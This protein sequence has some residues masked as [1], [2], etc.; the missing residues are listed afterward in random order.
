MHKRKI[1][2]V[3]G[4]RADYGLLYWSL[5]KIQTDPSLE[6]CLIATGQHLSIKHGLTHK[7]IENDGFHINHKVEMLLDADTSQSLIKGT[8]LGF[9]G[10]GL[11]LS[12]EN[13]DLLLVLGDR[14]E[15]FA[16]C[17]AATLLKLPIAHI[18][19]GEST[20][21]LMDEAFRHGITKMSHIHFVAT[22]FY[23]QR[24]IQLGENP[25]KVYTVGGMGVEYISKMKLISKKILEKKFN[26]NFYK[27]NI[28]VNYHPT[29]LEK[30]D[31]QILF[32][33]ILNALDRLKDTLIIFT[34][35]NSDP[36]N[37]VLFHMISE[38][39]SRD[40]NRKF[41]VSMGNENYLSLMSYCSLVLGNSSSGI[42]ETPSLKI[43][44]VNIGDRQKGRIKARNIIDCDFSEQSITKAIKKAL[45][46]NFQKNLSNLENPYDC[47]QGSNKIIE[48]L[49]GI[50]L[51]NILMKQFY[52]LSFK[53]E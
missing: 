41:F 5:K 19:G 11:A 25:S 33:E 3:T 49:R 4:S 38:F 23:R 45:S 16:A 31:S 24:V 13:P 29:T 12:K 7:A 52:D 17:F 39:C 20:E 36:E 48:V 32:I 18:H 50:N 46:K 26:F 47:G 35:P 14:Y 9:E 44:T 42:I 1:A 22:N 28:L 15:I 51:D 8:S 34:A 30:K 37:Q 27:N 43:P 10:M 40:K 53:C 21:G 2:V 6:L